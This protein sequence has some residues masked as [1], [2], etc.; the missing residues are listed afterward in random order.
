MKHT[1]V[2][3]FLNAEETAELFSACDALGFKRRKTQYGVLRRH[4]TVAF[5]S[6]PDTHIKAGDVFDLAV[7]PEA[8]KQLA[9][10][11][12]TYAGKDINYLAVVRY[13]DGNDYFNWHQ[14]KSDK[15]GRDMSVYIVST[16]AERPLALRLLGEKR[17]DVLAKQGS[18]IVLPSEYN[19]THEHAVPKCKAT[20]VR[21]AVNAKHIPDWAGK[22][23]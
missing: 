2:P 8:I 1:V 20:A 18:L 16:G 22:V 15:D 14:H 12:T 4:A 6:A 17:T 5:T 9:A 10:R 21:Y 13:A 11:L 19:N 3:N 7:A 23:I